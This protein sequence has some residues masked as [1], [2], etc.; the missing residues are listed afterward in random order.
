M[1]K[2]NNKFGSLNYTKRFMKDIFC[3]FKLYVSLLDRPWYVACISD[4]KFLTKVFRVTRVINSGISAAILIIFHYTS[5]FQR[6]KT[7]ACGLAG[8][9]LPIA[10]LQKSKKQVFS[11]FSTFLRPSLHKRQFE[12]K[13][14]NFSLHKR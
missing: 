8:H 2:Q 4:Q 7:I 1:R 13:C 14:I 5:F 6:W 9:G 3:K 10:G 12:K 11:K